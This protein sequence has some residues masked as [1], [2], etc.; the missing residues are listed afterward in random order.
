MFP[1]IHRLVRLGNGPI[2]SN[3]ISNAFG[4][5]VGG[6][7]ASAVGQANFALGVAE[8]RIGKLLLL[9]K[10]SVGLYV[11]GAG[12][13]D[14]YVFVFVTLDSI[15]ESDAFS[16]SPTGAGARVKPED[17]GLAVVITQTHRFARVV[18]HRKPGRCVS[19]LQHNSSSVEL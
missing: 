10:L 3:H 13:E 9:G 6:V 18:L 11:V 5:C 7:L 19:N 1:S 15:T 4:R 2:G 16:R 12:A 14:L 8:Q 17:H